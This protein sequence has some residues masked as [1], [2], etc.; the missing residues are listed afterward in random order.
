MIIVKIQ[1]GLGNQM[2]QY[3]LAKYMES[4]GKNVKIYLGHYSEVYKGSEDAI[5]NGY[6]LQQIFMPTLPIASKREALKYARVNRSFLSRGLNKVFGLKKTHNRQEDLDKRHCYFPQFKDLH[7]AYLEG[8][9]N[10]FLYAEEVKG[11]IMKEYKFK[12]ELSLRNAEVVKHMEDTISVSLH[13]RHGDYLKLQDRYEIPSLK[14]YTSAIE[15]FQKRFKKV[16]FFCFSD[17]IEWCRKH[18]DI[19]NIDFIDWNTG[20]D[21]YVDMQLMSRCKHNIIANSTFSMWAAWLNTYENKIVIRPK[22][23]FVDVENE[24]KDMWPKEWVIMEN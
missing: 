10:S 15:Y 20:A 13:I 5:H 17:D 11:S 14:Y 2:F 12:N 1:G 22:S 18:I 8:Y 9:W 19:S 23:V 6:E 7:D 21:S 4:M 3:A 24:K 16:H